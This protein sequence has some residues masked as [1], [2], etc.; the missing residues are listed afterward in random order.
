[1]SS[2]SSRYYPA[3]NPGLN[4]ARVPGSFLGRPY[5]MSTRKQSYQ[6]PLDRQ[7]A[8]IGNV[9]KSHNAHAAVTAKMAAAAIKQR[10]IRFDKA[11][12]KYVWA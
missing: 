10:N 1:M 7:V 6:S 8:Y 4:D 12:G 5:G 3:P 9:Y 11:T 2:R